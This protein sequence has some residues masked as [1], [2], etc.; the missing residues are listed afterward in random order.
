MKHD[1]CLLFLMG[2]LFAVPA[3][4]R[5]PISLLPAAAELR[6]I[7]VQSQQTPQGKIDFATGFTNG[8]ERIIFHF[9]APGGLY[10]AR[11]VY[12]AQGFKG[13]TFELNGLAYAASLT[14][15][16]DR[17]E[18]SNPVR[19]LL[20]AGANTLSIGGGWGHYDIARLDLLPIPIPPPPKPPAGGLSDPRASA[21]ARGLWARLING[22]G[23]KTLSGVY[24]DEDLKYV[25][26][27]TGKTPNILGADLSDYSPSRIEHGADP[28]KI[29]PRLVEQARA[30]SI[31]TLSWHWNAPTALVDNAGQTDSLP[32]E[33]RWYRG[34]NTGAT[35]FDFAAAL[36]DENSDGY[37]LLLRD[38]DAV[39]APLKMLSDARIPI[40][41]R[42]LHEAE[43]GWFWWG[44][45]GPDAYVKLWR[46]LHQ[47]LTQTHHLHNLIWVFTAGQDHRWYPGDDVVDIVGVDDYPKDSRDPLVADWQTVLTQFGDRKLLTLTEVGFVPDLNL[48]RAH[49]VYWSY[50]NTWNGDNG[51]GN[52]P[53]KEL[54]RRF[55]SKFMA[56]N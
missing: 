8:P 5:E 2:L 25:R 54:K 18:Q 14:S 39:A 9:D 7:T 12:R 46:L 13:Y 34:F 1:V 44:S 50:F 45:K 3:L 28:S 11:L 32:A 38:L 42:P 15:T 23:H 52:L 30:G 33:Q 51:P 4:A 16:S 41:W 22:Y 53:P 37:R 36:A 17:F 31:L 49:G 43:G 26:D 19:L 40:L 6:Q 47:R 56:S 24:A 27:Q 10:E 35:T 48:A 21:E 20:A 55:D 29:A